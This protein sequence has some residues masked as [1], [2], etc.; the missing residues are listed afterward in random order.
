MIKKSR[1]LKEE[2]KLKKNV[3]GTAIKIR[4]TKKQKK[5]LRTK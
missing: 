5:R 1:R 3:F 2:N 4:R